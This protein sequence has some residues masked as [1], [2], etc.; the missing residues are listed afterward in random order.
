MVGKGV[1]VFA[2]TC[3]TKVMAL[4]MGSVSGQFS[5]LRNENFWCEIQH[6]LDKELVLR[7]FSS[8][9]SFFFLPQ[10]SEMDSVMSLTV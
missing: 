1:K 5:L 9:N 3:K 8:E 2:F 4:F 6:F 7:A 10:L